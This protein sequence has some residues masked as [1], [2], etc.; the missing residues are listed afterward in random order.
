MK[1]LLDENVHRGL[2]SFLTELDHEVKL[3]PK[4]FKNSILFRLAADEERLLITRDSDFSKQ[5]YTSSKHCGIVLL[6]IPPKDLDAQKTA[7]SELFESETEFKGK[8]F[9]LGEESSDI[10]P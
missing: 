3:A 1:I 2:F 9:I 6:R 10:P 8:V 7:I 5:P 4:G